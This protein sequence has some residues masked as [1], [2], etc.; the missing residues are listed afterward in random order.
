[1][2]TVSDLIAR[3]R[4]HG[5]N[6]VLDAGKLRVVN[7]RKLPEGALDYIKAHGRAIVEF[8]DEEAAVEERAAIIEFDGGAPRKWAEQF[9]ALLI[10]DR[11]AGVSDLDWSW[12]ITRAGQIIDAGVDAF[13]PTARAA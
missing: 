9:A 5:A 13:Q 7:S 8:L 2:A 6:V 4:K 1:M 10:K 3:I 11:P 12:F